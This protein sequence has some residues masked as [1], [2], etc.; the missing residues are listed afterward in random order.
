MFQ[1]GRD[2]LQYNKLLSPPDGFYLDTT[3]GTTYS[4]DLETL[5]GIPLALA[6][7]GEA[8]EEDYQHGLVLLEAIRRLGGRIHLYCQAGQIALPTEQRPVLAF[9]EDSV[10]QVKPPEGYS[11]HPKL[12]VARYR[13]QKNKERELFRVA[14]LSR[15]LTFDRSWDLAVAMDGEP[16]SEE[17]AANEPLG[18]FLEYLAGFSNGERRKDVMQLAREVRRARFQPQLKGKSYFWDYQF[19][20]IGLAESPGLDALFKRRCH[21]FTIISPFL[22]AGTVKHLR[23]SLFPSGEMI[24]ISR[25]DSLQKLGEKALAKIDCWHLKN[26]VIDGEDML[27]EEAQIFRSRQDLH[28]KLYLKTRHGR[29][30]LWIG[31]ANC[32]RPAFSGNIEFLLRLDCYRYQLNSQV[33]LS[34]LMGSEPENEQNPFERWV[35]VPEEKPP[36]EDTWDKA[37]RDLVEKVTRSGLHAQVNPQKTAPQMFQL[38][39]NL[40]KDIP[41]PPGMEIYITPLLQSMRW[42]PLQGQVIFS[43][44]S[45]QWLSLF[46]GIQISGEGGNHAFVL[47][48]PV[49]GIPLAERDGAI[50]KSIVRDRQ[51]FLQYAALLLGDDPALSLAELLKNL[52]FRRGKVQYHHQY[53]PVLFEKM[54]VAAAHDPRRLEELQK[55]MEILAAA[56]EDLIP[57][58]F[59][60]LFGLFFKAIEGQKQ[61]DQ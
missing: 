41:L 8:G 17:L 45:L 14:V 9:L 3:V 23:K 43:D 38:L 24:L 29:T 58:D 7:G 48:V 16:G 59:R 39:V 44:L 52:G 31:S 2:R 27:E 49:D 37:V 40:D 30:S 42:Q 21:Q 15:N 20:P 56:D 11:F 26:A 33:L 1:P 57:R 53:P 22:N 12:W 5:L 46:F 60:E 61:G 34:Q 32:S 51:G 54:L 13:H 25:K 10:T 18:E 28:A 47:K 35:P 6:L 55:V 50:M 19:L 36:K 4:L